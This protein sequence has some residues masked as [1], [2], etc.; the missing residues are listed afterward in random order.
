MDVRA[1][2]P[3][4]AE[5]QKEPREFTETL[6][7]DV[8]YHDSELPGLADAISLKAEGGRYLPDA[9]DSTRS[10]LRK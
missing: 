3:R 2:Q 6:K 5:A 4:L 8:V 7:A 1:E 10:N 9:S